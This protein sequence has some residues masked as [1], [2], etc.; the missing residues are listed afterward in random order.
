MRLSLIAALLFP[1]GLVLAAEDRPVA[2]HYIE[3]RT[4]RVYACPCEWS[5]DWASRGREAILAWSIVS[6]EFGGTDLAGIRIVAVV[7]GDFALTEPDSPRR[8]V[9]FI[10]SGDQAARHV[11]GI[12]W[13]RN[14]YPAL[15]GNVSGVHESPVEFDYS[16][17]RAALTVGTVLS[18]RMR[19]A[20][21]PEDTQS[22]A[23]FIHD[24]F[25]RLTNPAVGLTTHV[26]YSGP[27]LKI[28][29]TRDENALT[30]YFGEFTDEPGI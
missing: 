27:D 9:V 2:G 15:L 12:A 3:D 16:A 19:R 1:L 28:R 22:W 6:G 11:A 13:L 30:G 23:Q 5:T 7:V 18:L 17:E 20:H 8:S 24:P 14:R 29:W 26:S 21:F 4:M 10:D 25:I